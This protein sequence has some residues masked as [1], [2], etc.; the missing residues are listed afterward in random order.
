MLVKERPDGSPVKVPGFTKLMPILLGSRTD[1]TIFMEMAFELNDTLPFIEEWNRT[2]PDAPRPLSLMQVSLAAMARAV[3][4]RPWI[5][6]FVSNDRYYQRNNIA[7]SFVTKKHLADD[8]TE[9]N[10]TMP[11]RPEDGLAD[12]NERFA[13]YVAQA[14]SEG[15]NESEKDVDTFEKLPIPLLR[16]I[17]WGLRFLDR[18]NW[19]SANMLRLLPFY[20]TAFFSNVGSLD[21]DAP[22]HHNFEI[23]NTGF[24]VALG[25]VNRQMVLDDEGRPRERVWATVSYT[26]DERVV[27]GAY[28]S[29]TINLVKAFVEDPTQLVEPLQLDEEQT[30]ELGLTDKGW[31]LWARE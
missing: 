28:G 7:F 23:G 9:V 8:G 12:V 19:V 3:A 27:D 1:A 25:R 21:I 17:L 24:F 10:V 18:H 16:A 29:K 6:R 11:F 5:N 22:L 31:Q 13:R 26:F 30:R 20:C 14:K 2:H 15:G 4:L